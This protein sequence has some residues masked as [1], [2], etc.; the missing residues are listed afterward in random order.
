MNPGRYIDNNYN[1]FTNV[2]KNQMDQK[3]P[4]RLIHPGKKPSRHNK[5]PWWSEILDTLWDEVS[6]REREWSAATGR[7]KHDAKAKLKQSQKQFDR[8]VQRS[9][10]NYWHD[11]QE[12]LLHLPN[13]DPNS[14]WKYI[15][16]LGIE[17]DRKKYLPT[18]IRTAN[19]SI[20]TDKNSIMDAW[21]THFADLLNDQNIN[22][23]TPT[24]L[25]HLNR[26]SINTNMSKPISRE[27]ILAALKKA[28]NG[29]AFG[30]DGVPTECLRNDPVIQYLV[31]LFNKCFEAGLTP[32][33]WNVGII[34]PIL[35]PGNKDNKDLTNYRGITIS[36]VVYKL[37]CSVLN[38]RIVDWCDFNKLVADEQNGFRGNRSC[39]DHICTLTNIIETRKKSKLATFSAFIDFSKAF[40]RIPRNALW[41][42]LES[43]RIDQRMLA[44]LKSLYKDVKCTVKVNGLN[45]VE[46]DV[47]SG[48]K[49]GCPLSPT[50]FNLFIN[51]CVRRINDLHKG[52]RLDDV[53]S[54]ELSMLLY[55][56]DVVLLSD[57]EGNLQNMLDSLSEWCGTWNFR[58]NGAKSKVVHFRNPSAPGTEHV[59]T[60]GDVSLEV[61]DK[62]KYLRLWLTEHLDYLLMTREI[63]NSAHRA[64][65]VLIAKSK[66]NGGM[67]FRIFSKLYNSLVM[68]IITYGAAVW[69]FK[70]YSSIN[71]VQNRASRFFLGLGKST[72]NAALHGE[73]GWNLPLEH[74]WI[75][76]GRQ[77][78]RMCNFDDDR[79]TK[80]VLRWAALK[81][82]QNRPVKNWVFRVTTH[83]ASVGREC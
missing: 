28:K 6:R 82:S 63:A 53:N 49:Q 61:T 73:I 29:K 38:A 10:R 78:A 27:E 75:T 47:S 34:S 23:V 13:N 81:A 14:F 46:F 83:F 21:K 57:N 9:K 48:L 15:G 26:A 59:F 69:G 40:D 11:E 43:M 2:V 35:K 37:Y 72:P 64:L 44:A 30:H 36:S 67:P 55:A 45:T 54:T 50:L 60:C 20:I 8:E 16:Q 56:D 74:Q 71:A 39:V 42:K 65:A 24:H 68:P 58:L 3:L 33:V 32:S 25:A 77:W 76:I 70:E 18:E 31:V 80:R 7:N 66:I 51:D 19:G 17:N 41:K 5:K 79:I 12:R 52:I 1:K 4:H 62:Y 22:N